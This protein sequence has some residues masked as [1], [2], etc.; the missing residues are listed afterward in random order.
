MTASFVLDRSLRASV[1]RDVVLMSGPDAVDYL[2][3]QLSADIVA[4]EVGGSTLSFLLDPRGRVEALLRVSRTGP[5]TFVADTEPGFGE[6]VAASLNRFKL[7]TRIEIDCSQW[8]MHAVRGP[9][10]SRRVRPS[11]QPSAAASDVTQGAALSGT[12][13]APCAVVSGRTAPR[14]PMP[15]ATTR[16]SRASRWRRTGRWPRVMTCWRSRAARRLHQGDSAEPVS[17][18]EFEALRMA[19][20]LP[21]MGTEIHPG[22]I[23]NETGVVERAAS[24]T[25]GCYRGQELV[26]RIDSRTGGR[27]TIRRFRAEAQIAPGHELRDAVG[28]AAGSVLSV[29]SLAG[30][31]GRLRADPARRRRRCP[32]SRRSAGPAR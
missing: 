30:A 7:R 9:P 2:H 8:T 29:S 26:E 10:G 6:P 12:R 25:K 3:G 11:P 17:A 4:L 13:R 1:P 15:P 28:A 24:F 14:R 21:A 27:R 22:D 5:E 18:A 20:G 32:N 23:P 16:R 31:L 19:F